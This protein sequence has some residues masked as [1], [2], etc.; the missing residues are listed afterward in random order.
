MRNFFSIIMLLFLACGV[1]QPVGT[2]TTTDFGDIFVESGANRG[3]IYLDHQPAGKTTPDTLRQVP[4]GAH[5][6]QVIQPG[7]RSQPDSIVVPVE[8]SQLAR[9]NFALLP[10]TNTGFL[11]IETTPARGE[12]FLDNQPTGQITPDT[13]QAEAGTHFIK[14][15]KNG[16]TDL[17]REVTIEPNA[18]ETLTGE[19]QIQSRVLLEAFGNVSCTPCVAAA[20]NLHRFETEKN[21][22]EYALIEYYA[23]WPSPNDPFFRVSPNDVFQRLGIYNVTT[24]PTLVLDGTRGV[25]A[26]DYHSIIK[27]FNEMQ[28]QHTEKI[29]LSIEKSWV[30]DSLQVFVQIYHFE[31]NLENPDG[32]LFVAVIENEIHFANPPGTN[33]LKDFNF[34]FRKFLS[35]NTGDPISAPTQTVEKNYTLKWPDWNFTNCQ[36]VAFVQQANTRQIIQTTIR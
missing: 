8:K 2:E 18:F 25:D 27:N 23:N 3:S 15:V 10:L 17:Y 21:S 5:V 13:L 16:Y 1:K 26:A 6:V 31:K 28:I 34:V 22:A 20:T 7:F 11:F 33:G 9:V 30:N 24:L 12:I 32:R 35:A 4:V 36:V 14:I 19:F 29:G